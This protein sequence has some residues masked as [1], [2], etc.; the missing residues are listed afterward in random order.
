MSDPSVNKSYAMMGAQDPE[1]RKNDNSVRVKVRERRLIGKG[2][3]TRTCDPGLLFFSTLCFG[4]IT[5]W[6]VWR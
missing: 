2:T 6:L 1:D 3:N 4:E 5:E